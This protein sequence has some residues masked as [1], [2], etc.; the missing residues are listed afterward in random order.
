MSIFLN[1]IDAAPIANS[2]FDVQ[3]LQWIWILV[4]VLNEN[5]NDIQNS[6]NLLTG[7]SYTPTEINDMETAGDLSNGVILYDSVNHVYVGRQ[8]GA[9]VQFTTASYP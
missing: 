2:N 6:F 3:F 7:Q 4:E 5:I 9:L 8:N 1:R